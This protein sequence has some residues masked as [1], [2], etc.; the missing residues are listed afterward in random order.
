MSKVGRPI[1]DHADIVAE[2]AL[3]RKLISKYGISNKTAKLTGRSLS[4]LSRIKNGY[5]HKNTGGIL[6]NSLQLRYSSKLCRRCGQVAQI[7]DKTCLCIVCALMAMG[8][9]GI[10]EIEP[11]EDNE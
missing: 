9:Q 1:K 5:R 8:S 2:I 7:V 10:I 6:V 3:V 11:E 4:N